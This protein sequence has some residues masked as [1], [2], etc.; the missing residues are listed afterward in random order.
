MKAYPGGSSD[1]ADGA[2][3]KHGVVFSLQKKDF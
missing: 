1:A 2:L 3:T